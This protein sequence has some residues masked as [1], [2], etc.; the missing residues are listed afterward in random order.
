MKWDKKIAPVHF[1]TDLVHPRWTAIS[2]I[3]HLPWF[4][5]VRII[6]EILHFCNA[7]FVCCGDFVE[8]GTFP[9]IVILYLKRETFSDHIMSSAQTQLAQG[10]GKAARRR[11]EFMAQDKK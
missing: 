3:L 4:R 7:I 8:S 6:Q 11:L 9:T 2:E 1:D 5:R 10:A